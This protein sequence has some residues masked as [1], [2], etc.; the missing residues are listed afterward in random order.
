MFF[1]DSFYCLCNLLQVSLDLHRLV[2]WSICDTLYTA[3]LGD[4]NLSTEHHQAENIVDLSTNMFLKFITFIEDQHFSPNNVSS[5]LF[6]TL[7]PMLTEDIQS[8]LEGSLAVFEE[9]TVHFPCTV[10]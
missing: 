8:N 6:S 9:K 5:H 1:Y 7:M 4:L 2:M 10:T 3:V